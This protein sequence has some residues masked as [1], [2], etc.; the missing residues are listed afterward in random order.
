MICKFSLHPFLV[1]AYP[2]WNCG[3]HEGEFRVMVS[4]VCNAINGPQTIRQSQHLEV[5]HGNLQNMRFFQ[6]GLPGIGR[7]KHQL[8]D[9]KVSASPRRQKLDDGGGVSWAR[10]NLRFLGHSLGLGRDTLG[11]LKEV[12]WKRGRQGTGKT[13]SNGP[14]CSKLLGGFGWFSER[15]FPWYFPWLQLLGAGLDWWAGRK[16]VIG[17]GLGRLDLSEG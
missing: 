2:R 7:Q 6:V 4:S 10:W 15:D 11:V 13:G 14:E 16:G 3:K 5:W 17:S 9:P 1:W 8:M 12:G